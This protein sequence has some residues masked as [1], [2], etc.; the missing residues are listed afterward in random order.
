MTTGIS[1]RMLTACMLSLAVA[2]AAC[3][4]GTEDGTTTD[5]G[6]AAEPGTTTGTTPTAGGGAQGSPGA[7]TRQPGGSATARFLDREGRDIGQVTLVEGP[8]GVFVHGQ[9]TGL[10]PGGHGFHFHQVGRCEPPFETAGGHFNP[11]GRQHGLA[12]TSG[13]HAGDMANIFADANGSAQIEA[14]APLV[15]LGSGAHGLLDADGTAILIHA[16]PD[17]HT[18]DPSGNS[19]DRIACAVLQRG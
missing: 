4:P 14:F 16:G 11:T 2:T 7:I 12:S 19:G 5:T 13:P 6:A 8:E 17:D 10:T 9:V 3:A 15:T 1:S 18:T